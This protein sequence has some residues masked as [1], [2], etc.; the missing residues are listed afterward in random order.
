MPN[1]WTSSWLPTSVKQWEEA[2]AELNLTEQTMH[3]VALPAR[4]KVQLP[5]S[6][7]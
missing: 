1:R 2:V 5:T 3:D 7:T 6:Q 4:F